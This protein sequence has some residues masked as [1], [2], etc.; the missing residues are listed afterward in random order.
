[1]TGKFTLA[2]LAMAAAIFAAPAQPP[3]EFSGVITDTMCGARPHSAM[4]KDKTDAD[5]VRICARGS[6]A[7]ALLSGGS[8]MKLSDQKTTAKYAGQKVRVTGM[9][10]EKSK[11]LRVVSIAPEN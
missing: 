9:Y 7:Y 11:T 1:M 10:D 5:C 3:T 6:S 4:M 2:S 8:V